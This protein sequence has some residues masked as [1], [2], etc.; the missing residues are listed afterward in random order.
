MPTQA[1]SFAAL[2]R[3]H[4]RLLLLTQQELAEKS[5]LSTRTIQSIEAGRA[6]RPRPSSV[7][8][9]GHAFGLTGHD[10][11]A[12]E[13]APRTERAPA[14]FDEVDLHSPADFAAVLEAA[15]AHLRAGLD[16]LTIRSPRTPDRGSRTGG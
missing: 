10:L 7:R 1:L 5:G 16:L 4:R 14:T 9:L 12:F 15:I 6:R 13:R 2:V 11:D 8:L 3:H